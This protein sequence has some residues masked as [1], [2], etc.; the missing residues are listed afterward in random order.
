[1][2]L[3]KIEKNKATASVVGFKQ[4]CRASTHKGLIAKPA[5]KNLY[6]QYNEDKYA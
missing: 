2:F 3:A 5:K 1:M 4:I 6:L